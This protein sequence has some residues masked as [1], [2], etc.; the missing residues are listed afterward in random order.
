MPEQVLFDFAV[1]DELLK[2]V[3]SKSKTPRRSPTST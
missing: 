3:V 2:E 1:P